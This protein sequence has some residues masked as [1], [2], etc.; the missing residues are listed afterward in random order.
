VGVAG[1]NKLLQLLKAFGRWLKQMFV[2]KTAYIAPKEVITSTVTTSPESLENVEDTSQQPSE[3]SQP[4]RLLGLP[5]EL[6]LQILSYTGPAE[7][8]VVNATC[9]ELSIVAKDS[10]LCQSLYKKYFEKNY[11]MAAV[12]QPAGKQVYSFWYNQL[13]KAHHVDLKKSS[14][15]KMN[16][17]APA[18]TFLTGL[19][20][21]FFSQSL[22]SS[23][24]AQCSASIPVPSFYSPSFF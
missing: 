18:P 17:T 21:F 8:K 22:L 4:S 5:H 12:N 23:V 24:A 3:M 1:V 20:T 6:L 13:I 2:P 10:L 16:A 9:S 15:I 19:R 7:L 14:E 11:R